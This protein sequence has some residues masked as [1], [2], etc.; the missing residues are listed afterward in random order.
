M[1]NIILL[2]T[3]ILLVSLGMSQTNSAAFLSFSGE[4]TYKR[5]NANSKL[6]FPML[7][8][9]GD[10][11][12]LTSG[13]ALL[14][15]ADGSEISLASG[16][17]YTIPHL[18]KEEMLV[19]LDASIFQDFVVQSQSNSSVNLRGDS[20]SLILYPIS[21]KVINLEDA[22]IFFSQENKKTNIVFEL[23]DANSLDLIYETEKLENDLLNVKILKL[24][25]GIEYAW[26][27]KIKE[28]NTEQLGIIS[29]L[30]EKE[31]AKQPKFQYNN[32][33]DYLKAYKYYE[34]NEFYFEAYNIIEKAS[35]KYKNIDLFQYMLKKMRFRIVD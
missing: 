17:E 9:G 27:M 6:K 28:T 16:N 15:V 11:I 26:T 30:T 35:K 5:G 3:F 23:F 34:R 22:R 29:V 14:M 8:S 18:K 21:S 32:K 13:S 10:K 19:E 2:F 24:S 12:K 25:A 1:K 31:I 7:F 20:T 4:G 33:I